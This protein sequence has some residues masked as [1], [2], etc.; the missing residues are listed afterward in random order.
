LHPDLGLVVIDVPGHMVF[1]PHR[2]EMGTPTYPV[3]V[4]RTGPHG[5]GEKRHQRKRGRC[6]SDAPNKPLLS[7]VL[8]VFLACENSDEHILPG[9]L[10][11]IH[12][13]LAGLLVVLVQ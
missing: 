3:I 9:I 5:D 11:A 10:N 8:K 2:I 13:V 6:S 4:G 1:G 7:F 12:L